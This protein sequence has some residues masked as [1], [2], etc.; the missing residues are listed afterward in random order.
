[1]EHMNNRYSEPKGIWDT[2]KE[3]NITPEGLQQKRETYEI[4]QRFAQKIMRNL[5][6]YALVANKMDILYKNASILIKEIEEY[7]SKEQAEMWRIIA[8]I[9]AGHKTT[10]AIDAKI[11]KIQADLDAFDITEADISLSLRKCANRSASQEDVMEY[12]E[13]TNAFCTLFMD[14]YCDIEDLCIQYD[15][16]RYL[17]QE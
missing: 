5:R 13:K 15:E 6:R 11:Q 16:R 10:K 4:S 9:K 17:L 8:S 1:M 2:I 7:Y 12:D 14:I 3:M